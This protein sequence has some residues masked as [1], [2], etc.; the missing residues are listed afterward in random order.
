MTPLEKLEQQ[1]LERAAA[2]AQKFVDALLV[3]IGDL[4][5][6]VPLMARGGGSGSRAA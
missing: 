5:A 3:Q 6:A 4:P 2:L 1:E